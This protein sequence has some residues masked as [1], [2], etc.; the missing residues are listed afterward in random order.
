MVSKKTRRASISLEAIGLGS[1]PAAACFSST[2]RSMSL[3]SHATL[4]PAGI[5]GGDRAGSLRYDQCSR[6]AAVSIVRWLTS[7]GAASRGSGA[8]M[9]IQ[10]SKSTITAAGS[11]PAGGISKPSCLSAANRRLLSRFPGTTA[12]P[13]SPPFSIPA[14]ESTSSSAF[15]LPACNAAD[16][17]H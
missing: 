3:R 16:E 17:W 11:L 1:M 10:V 2:K 15:S 9:S 4:F 6:P 7:T 5:T 12:G 8:P 14:R 13:V